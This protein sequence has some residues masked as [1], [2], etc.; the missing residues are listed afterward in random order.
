MDGPSGQIVI[1]SGRHKKL[2]AD[3][4]RNGRSCDQEVNDPEGEIGKSKRLYWDGLRCKIF[5]WTEY[6]KRDILFKKWFWKSFQNDIYLIE[7]ESFDSGNNNG[8]ALEISSIYLKEFMCLR[9]IKF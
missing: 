3:D 1:Y 7:F 5:F 4:L 6:F 9:K 2:K 8:A